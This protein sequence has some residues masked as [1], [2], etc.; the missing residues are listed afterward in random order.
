MAYEIPDFTYTLPAA[1]DLSA[2]QYRFL[3]ATGGN[4][5]LAGAGVASVGVLQNDPSVA[6]Q[7][8][9]IMATGISKVV[10]GAAVV[11]GTKVMTDAQARAITATGTNFVVG[12]ALTAAGAANEVISV[13]VMPL[14]H[15]AL[16]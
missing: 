5:T 15:N 12:V 16:V 10:A 3:V 6:G 7:A 14:G 2:N 8:A 4:A 11:A 13:L 1:D 9:G